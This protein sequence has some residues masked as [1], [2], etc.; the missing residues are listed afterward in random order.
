MVL[1]RPAIV[2]KSK[3]CSTHCIDVVPFCAEKETIHTISSYFRTTN[4]IRL[5]FWWIPAHLI[6]AIDALMFNIN[7]NKNIAD[8][9]MQKILLLFS[10]FN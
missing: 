6:Y 8:M 1:G 2:E 7:G 10:Q 3:F 9:Q 5:S 4:W